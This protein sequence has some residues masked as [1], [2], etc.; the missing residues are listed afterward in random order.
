MNPYYKFT[1]ANPRIL[2]VWK[3]TR[4]LEKV[5]KKSFHHKLLT[6]VN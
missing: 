3:H 5:E 6:S 4:I 1:S 2:K